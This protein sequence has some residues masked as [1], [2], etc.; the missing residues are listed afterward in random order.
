MTPVLPE[1][2]GNAVSTGQLC[3]YRCGSWIGDLAFATF[4]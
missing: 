4:P 2:N 3:D 1:M